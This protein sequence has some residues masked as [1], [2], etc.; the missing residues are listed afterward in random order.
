MSK[1]IPNF[2]LPKPSRRFNPYAD[3][4]TYQ[5]KDIVFQFSEQVE[6]WEVH[7]DGIITDKNGSLFVNGEEAQ[8]ERERER[9][10]ERE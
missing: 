2:L 6:R 7:P 8:S 3:W 10:R 1:D 5:D 9:E 4:K